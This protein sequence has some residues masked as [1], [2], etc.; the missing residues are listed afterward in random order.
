MTSD[1]DQGQPPLSGITVLALEQAIAAPLC[2]RHLADLGARVI[3]IEQPGGGDMARHYDGTVR[4]LGAHFV[5][6]NHGKQSAALDLTEPADLDVFTGLL[7]CADV[8]VSNLAP[9][10]LGRLGLAPEDLAGR[11]PRLIVVDISGYGQ[12]GPLDHKR[13][14]DLLVQAEGG[15]C[16]I[17]G[18]PGQPVKSGIPIADIGTAL[19]AYSS[20]LAALYQRERTGRGAVIPIAM[21]DVV[22]EMMG[23][24]LNRVLHGGGELQP[25]GMGSPMVAP[26]GAY[27]AADGQMAVLGTTSD[28]EWR[29]LACD[30]LGRPDLAEDPRYAHNGDRVRHRAELD[31][32]LGAWC[33]QHD[34]AEIQR[35]ADDAGIGNARLNTVRDLAEHTQLAARN[36]W[37]QVDTPGGPVPAL[38]PPALARDWTPV[39]GPVPALGADTDAIRAEVSRLRSLR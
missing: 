13:A 38:L 16:A 26:Y 25:V 14:Y 27:P 2:T 19:Y 35:R 15:S 32:I 22:G 24:A 7:E 36:R 6:L 33:A 5:W 21:L 37:R 30:M 12:G 29:R 8:L 23:F 11:Y 20:V 9:G 31:Q 18:F 1:H 4:G 39:S 3:K 17:T 34:L 28:R 10:A